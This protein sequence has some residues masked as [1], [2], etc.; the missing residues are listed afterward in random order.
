MALYSENSAAQGGI[1][2]NSIILTLKRR[3]GVVACFLALGVLGSY[4]FL[5][6]V[7]AKYKASAQFLFDPTAESVVNP[8]QGLT[9]SI[10]TIRALE[11][12]I[13]LIQSPGT[14]KQ[15]AADLVSKPIPGPS[16][17]AIQAIL[18]E[19]FPAEELRI[20]R[21][22]GQLQRDLSIKTEAADQIVIV[23][24]Q[25]RS[26]QEAAYIANL[27][28]R[29]FIAE[30]TATRKAAVSQATEWLDERFSEAKEKLLTIDK[31]IQEYKAAQRI[32]DDAG[33]SAYDTQLVR[34]REQLVNVQGK[35]TDAETQFKMLQSYVQ[36][37]NSDFAKLADTLN[38]GNLQKLRASLA[39]A[40]GAA[41]A[42]K[43]RYGAFHPDVRGKKIL[44][45]V[46]R[47]EIEAEAKRKL[48]AAKSEVGALSNQQQQ[49]NVNIKVAEDKIRDLRAAEV[50]LREFQ[51]DR[52]A[53]KTLYDTM[54]ARLTKTAPQQTFG[55]ADFKPLVEAVAPD[56]KK[57]NP[58][59]V[60]IAGGI[61]G[62]GLGVVLALLLDFLADRVVDLDDVERQLQIRVLSRI[63]IISR[64]DIKNA[65]GSRWGKF[66]QTRYLQYAKEV[67]NS[68]FTNCLL[69]VLI[70]TRD[71]QVSA[72]GKVIA[73]TSPAP[74]NGKTLVTS[75]LASLS[76]LL[77]GSALLIDLDARKGVLEEEG[78][79]AM[80][81]A[82]IP[83]LSSFLHEASLS[84]T[85]TAKREAEF[86]H[87][88]RPR[89]SGEAIWLKFFQP[90]L[91]ELIRFARENYDYVWID[92][93][94]AQLFSDV[95][96]LAPQVDGLIIVAEWSK[97]T[98]RQLRQT[99]EVLV[100]SGGKV[101]GTVIN[102]VKVDGLVSESM[103][104]YRHY[105][106][107]AEKRVLQNPR[108]H[109]SMNR[110]QRLHLAL[111]G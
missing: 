97:T 106:D 48:F 57:L 80:N 110:W 84:H 56:T 38:D 102:K 86:L 69:Q 63:P 32:D 73:V 31:Q 2:L 53:V 88:V 83:E 7:P 90:Q 35:L 12:V 71:L 55:F 59:I 54:L 33:S 17:T 78:Q 3:L 96:A 44:A 26:P 46:L 76:Y 28:V 92:T 9:A 91:G 15:V 25:S 16:K 101:L 75:N 19:A 6:I 107:A 68:L 108:L 49:L 93:P 111:T 104:A 79:E 89:A 99:H 72:G 103:A 77:G 87:T 64:R 98:K 23:E 105:Y 41:A 13:A 58:I 37:G 51:R 82:Q 20:R 10:L 22:I 109:M 67:P 50:K 27:I 74:E 65:S 8:E 34:L 70:A 85:L 11:R 42:A 61:G 62:L 39:E 24:Y 29:D 94:P 4:L 95:L 30:R 14:L 52:E 5:A 40:E 36:G 100:R 43:E 45:Q 81:G 21:L 47:E 1:R 60:W 66:D 18:H